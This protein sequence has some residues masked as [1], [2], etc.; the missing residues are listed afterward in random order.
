MKEWSFM[1]FTKKIV[2]QLILSVELVTWSAW[3]Y[4][5][6]KGIA[7]ISAMKG[8]NAVFEQRLNDLRTKIAIHEHEIDQ[9]DLSTFYKEK[10]AREQLQMARHNDIIFYLTDKVCKK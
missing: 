3:Y 6:Q 8:N 1:M 10:I 9:W 2:V 7:A 5:G 4:Y